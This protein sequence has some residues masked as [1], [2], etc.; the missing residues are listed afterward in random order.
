[1]F[2][3]LLNSSRN[4][5]QSEL[6]WLDLGTSNEMQG[7]YLNEGLIHQKEGFGARGVCYDCYE[8]NLK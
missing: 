2:S 8:M 5:E 1:M 6:E 3:Q 7:R 4:L